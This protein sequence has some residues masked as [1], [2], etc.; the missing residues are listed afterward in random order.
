MRYNAAKKQR[1]EEI[2]RI[3]EKVKR[4]GYGSLSEEEKRKLFDASQQ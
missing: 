4:E 3:L 1:A 2:D